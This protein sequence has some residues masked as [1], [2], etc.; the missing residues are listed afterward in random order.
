MKRLTMD[1]AAK[2]AAR[3]GLWIRPTVLDGCGYA[4]QY[5][6]KENFFLQVPAGTEIKDIVSLLHL[7]EWDVV[8]PDDVMAEFK[9]LK[10]MKNGYD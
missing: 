10:E 8:E 9:K 6:K 7:E 4:F 2:L 1:S 5:Q 3:T